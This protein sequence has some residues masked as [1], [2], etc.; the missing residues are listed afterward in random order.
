M[1]WG[2]GSAAMRFSKTPPGSPAAS[3][4]RCPARAGAGLRSPTAH[5]APG[6]EEPSPAPRPP[7]QPGS[8]RRSP[9]LK[10]RAVP[11]HGS[12]SA[13]RR[14]ER[15]HLSCRT[16]AAAARWHGGTA[17]R[18]SGAEETRRDGTA[19][20]QR[21]RG[22][23]RR[24][25]DP[26]PVSAGARGRDWGPGRS[27]CRSPRPRLPGAAQSA[28]AALPGRWSSSTSAF[29]LLSFAM[30]AAGGSAAVSGASS[31][32]AARWAAPGLLHAAP[33]PAQ[34]E[35]REGERRGGFCRGRLLAPQ[36]LSFSPSLPAGHGAGSAFRRAPGA[37]SSPCRSSATSS[38][39]SPPEPRSPRCPPLSSALGVL[40]LAGA[41][42][43][44]VTPFGGL[45]N[46][47]SPHTSSSSPPSSGAHHRLLPSVPP[48]RPAPPGAHRPSER[49]GCGTPLAP[50]T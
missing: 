42:S 35:R 14:S 3:G 45:P 46:P 5:A 21:H 26:H 17:L 8:Q 1:G 47:L 40:S 28:H 41:T 43:F 15:R 34:G 12:G 20:Q 4:R 39:R 19:V 48:G 2:R 25:R 10:R 30:G 37:G 33:R 18:R 27:G 22:R 31:R 6:G 50:A 32:G 49:W 9:V 36:P 38:G 7:P 16:D 23:P 24:S 11:A 13:G 44:P 29:L